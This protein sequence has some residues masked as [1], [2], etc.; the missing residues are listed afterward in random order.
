MTTFEGVAQIV[1]PRSI[2]TV[3]PGQTVDISGQNPVQVSVNQATTDDFVRFVQVDEQPYRNAGAAQQYVSPDVTGYQDLNRY[4]QWQQTPNYGAVWMPQVAADWAPYRDGRWAYVAPWGWTWVDDAPWG[5]APFHY[6]RWVQVS[7]RWGWM[8]GSYVERPVYAPALVSFFGGFDLGGVG[9]SVGFGPAVG[10]V[11]LGPEEVYVPPYRSSPRY[12]HNVNITNVHNETTIINVVNNKSVINNYNNYRNHNGATIVQADAMTGSRPIAPA[13]GKLTPDQRNQFN[14]R[15]SQ[16]NVAGNNAPVKPTWKTAGVTQHLA[17]QL[18]VQPPAG[19]QNTGPQA[20]GPNSHG[21]AQAAGNPGLTGQPQAL[22]NS[23]LHAQVKGPFKPQTASPATAGGSNTK[24]PTLLVGQNPGG[25]KRVVNG[26]M[27]PS[28]QFKIGAARGQSAE[29]TA[30]GSPQQ[31]WPHGNGKKVTSAQPPPKQQLNPQKNGQSGNQNW[32][33]NGEES[34]WN[35]KADAASAAIR[36]EAA[37]ERPGR[38]SGLGLDATMAAAEQSAQWR[39]AKTE[40]R[41]K[42][43]EREGPRPALRQHG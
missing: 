33:P 37:E 14:K 35:R 3:G 30:L 22:S 39:R 28:A 4:G 17:Q 7:S 23:Q 11:P 2:R 9:I 15:W 25:N 41:T 10:W 18:G 12:I 31:N 26:Q 43:N 40:G 8:P 6:G 24:L 29:R 38:Q 19:G 34:R 27:P 36:R 1:G 5:F 32:R 16:S 20:P 13:Y 42:T 21:P